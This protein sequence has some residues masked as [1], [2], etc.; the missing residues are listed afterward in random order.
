MPTI[1]L[2]IGT[3]ARRKLSASSGQSSMQLKQ[4]KHSLLRSAA[5]GIGGALAVAQAEVAVGALGEVAVDAP[6]GEARQ[7]AQEGAQRAEHPAEE[8]GDDQVHAHQ[9][10]QHQPHEPGAGEH[11][12]VGGPAAR[13]RRKSRPAGSTAPASTPGLTATANERTSRQ[14]G[15][16][17]P[18]CSEPNAAST[19]K[20][21]RPSTSAGRSGGRRWPRCCGGC[22]GC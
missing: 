8:A 22:G 19:R 5:C 10:H 18:I 4:T 11:P 20:I 13:R 16:S 3:G 21:V 9:R 12:R 6:E 17:R 2:W 7:H 14:M 1:R 15:S